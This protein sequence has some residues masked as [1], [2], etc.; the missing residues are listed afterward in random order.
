MGNME[1]LITERVRRAMDEHVF[2]GCTVAF[3]KGDVRRVM[4]FG[5]LTYNDDAR[6]VDAETIYDVASVT[7]AIPTASLLLKFI[8][9]G[10][11]AIDDRVVDYIPAF[12]TAPEK[13]EVTLRHLLTYTL[14][15]D[16]PSLSSLK[17]EGPD[18]IIAA[19]LSASLRSKPGARFIYTNA[20]AGIMGLVVEAIGKKKLPELAA[21]YFFGP[22][23]MTRTTFSPKQFGL[24]NV[25]P[26]E[27][28]EW[29]GHLVHGEVHDESAYVM[30]QKMAIGSAGLFSTASDLLLFLEML[31]R[32]GMKDGR[33]YFSDAII[34]KMGENQIADLGM[35][36]G[37]GWELNQ[38]W[39]MGSNAPEQIFGK[40]GFTGR[41]VMVNMPQQAALVVLSNQTYPKRPKTN[42]ASARLRADIADIIFDKEAL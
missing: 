18:G 5:R 14:D 10:K 1:D 12:D 30:S 20:T 40:S 41:A 24:E 3:L 28:D 8:D 32:S 33:R 38:P 27:F 31:V 2:P 4:P 23:K 19:T 29:R 22:L 13:R 15:L 16:L 11:A 9:E 34:R 25:A 21:E 36:A 37:L 39:F 17:D 42:E 7:K 6:A 35:S 26:T